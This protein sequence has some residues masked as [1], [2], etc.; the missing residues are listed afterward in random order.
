MSIAPYFL[1]RHAEAFME[2]GL[3]EHLTP[4]GIIQAEQ[5]RDQLIESGLDQNTL[6]LSSTAPRAVETAEI[7]AEGLGAGVET[8]VTIRRIGEAPGDRS[9]AVLASIVT[10]LEAKFEPVEE[11][12]P[13][14]IVGHQPLF[15]RLTSKKAI[16]NGEVI[17]WDPNQPKPKA[18]IISLGQS[19]PK[20]PRERKI[21]RKH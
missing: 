15:V 11:G 10:G 4:E 6:V 16:G 1:V 20:P 9:T 5:A 3:V 8:A 13:V 14:V 2:S 21:F 18:P 7:I 12:A 19:R 17:E